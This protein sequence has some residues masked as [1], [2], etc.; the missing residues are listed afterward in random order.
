MIVESQSSLCLFKQSLQIVSSPLHRRVHQY[1]WFQHLALICVSLLSSFST[2]VS[3]EIILLGSVSV[4]GDAHDLSELEG[5]VGNG[6][7][8]NLFGAISG[9]EHLDGN[10]YLALPD[11]GPLD[12]TSQ[13]QC[14]CHIV[15]LTIDMT[16]KPAA[17]FRLL[18]TSLL[19]TE[20]DRP[21][22]GALEGFDLKSPSKSLRF[23]P[24]GVR[25]NSNGS[26]F[27]SD[28][29]G[30]F[31]YEFDMAGSDATESSPHRQHFQLHT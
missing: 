24:E 7:P 13:F 17:G 23:D 19:K 31:L 15:E 20:D 28:E 26:V 11:R 18:E 10:R 1:F 16:K 30:P 3:G 14:R 21:L 8:H 9:L 6:T 12:G 22:I 2:R 4:P 25:V 5:T 29:Y 27:V